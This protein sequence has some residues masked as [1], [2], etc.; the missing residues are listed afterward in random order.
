MPRAR[1]GMAMM[2]MIPET[3]IAVR[4]MMRANFPADFAPSQLTPPTRM[5][6]PM[7]SGR[8]RC[9]GTWK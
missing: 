4:A 7:A 1:A 5:I 8:T 2:A 6:D 9:S 3:A